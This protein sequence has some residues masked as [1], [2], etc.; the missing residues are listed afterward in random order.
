MS[1]VKVLVVDDSAFMRQVISG[2]L[3]T[4]PEVCVVGI[5]R[6]GEDAL[7]KLE[8]FDPDVVTLDLEMPK[9]DGLAF[10]ARLMSIRLVPVVVVSSWAT[11]GAEQTVRALE[12]GAVDFVTK[13]VAVPSEAMWDIREELLAKVK[14]AAAANIAGSAGFASPAALPAEVRGRASNAAICC[15]AAST[16][17]PRAL[18]S[19]VTRLP[20]DF[21]LGVLLVQHMPPGFTRVFAA[22]LA[23]ISAL[24]VKEAQNGQSLGPGQ[25]LVAPA[26][27]QTTVVG[28]AE[29]PKVQVG[30]TPRSVFRPSADISFD[31]IAETCGERALG[32]ILT[33][34]GQDGA[35]G[36]LAMHNCGARTVAESAETCVVFGMPRA[37]AELGAADLVLPL[38]QI[39]DA[40]LALVGAS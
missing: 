29:H 38:W 3:E 23:E 2:M 18:Q 31:S 9:M 6:D 24:P 15:I 22:H 19:I 33:G 4:D 26:G 17:G 21:P 10:L 40:L 7:N 32:V 34:M 27:L 13:P 16:G 20:A 39:P 5:A 12:L 37:A 30:S 25:V 36:L 1:P 14:T 8:R 28:S 35:R 11:V